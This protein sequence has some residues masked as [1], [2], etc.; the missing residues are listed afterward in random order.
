MEAGRCQ[1]SNIEHQMFPWSQK[2]L[3]IDRCLDVVQ[4]S[5]GAEGHTRLRKPIVLGA[6]GVILGADFTGGRG[7][8]NLT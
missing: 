5:C 4:W 1:L 6:E 2:N 3:G 8:E 7:E